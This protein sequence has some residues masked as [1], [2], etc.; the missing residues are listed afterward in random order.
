[1][2]I[3][4]TLEERIFARVE[5]DDPLGCWLWLGALTTSGYG[6][7]WHGDRSVKA[8]RATYELL[9]SDIPDGLQLDHLC[10]NRACVNPW[11][12]EPVTSAENTRRGTVGWA[13]SNKDTCRNRLH[14]WPESKIVRPN[15]RVFCRP[16]LRA[17][18]LRNRRSRMEAAA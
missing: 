13:A 3:N 5:A 8:H 14:P 11:H 2:K 10:R 1:M 6:S 4:G 9:I 18:A 16:C 12:L 7:V 15:G 17:R